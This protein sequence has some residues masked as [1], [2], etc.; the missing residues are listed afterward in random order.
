MVML[1]KNVSETTCRPIR[2]CFFELV[3]RCDVIIFR[4]SLASPLKI[5]HWEMSNLGPFAE[6][7]LDQNILSD[8]RAKTRSQRNGIL[9]AELS[10]ATGG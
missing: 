6:T 7:P 10:Y 9:Q 1:Y 3:L 5:Q 4:C 8:D 2:G